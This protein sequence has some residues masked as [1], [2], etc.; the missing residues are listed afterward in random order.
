MIKTQYLGWRL[1]GLFPEG[2]GWVASYSGPD[3]GQRARGEGHSPESALADAQRLVQRYSR[4]RLE[5]VESQ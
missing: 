4:N 5:D 1:S 3:E 2:E